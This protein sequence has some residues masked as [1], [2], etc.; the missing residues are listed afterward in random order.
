MVRHCFP[1]S[2]HR[3]NREVGPPCPHAG[4]M[5]SYFPGSGWHDPK[6]PP[7]TS[8]MNFCSVLIMS[9]SR[10][11]PSSLHVLISHQS[12]KAPSFPF[13]ASDLAWDQPLRH[14]PS[15]LQGGHTFAP[16]PQQALLCPRWLAAPRHALLPL[17]HQPG[18]LHHQSAFATGSAASSELWPWTPRSTTTTPNALVSHECATAMPHSALSSS[19]WDR[20]TSSP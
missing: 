16:R 12:P 20:A 18:A 3:S 11:S 13:L 1:P 7:S 4:A 10:P 8:T 19:H 2:P 14:R 9:S 5:P 6:P 15:L 17:H